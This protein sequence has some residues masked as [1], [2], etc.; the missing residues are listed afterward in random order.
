MR[1]YVMTTGVAFGLLAL[2]HVLRVAQEGWGVA[3]DPV[4]ILTSLG[5][6]GI[7]VWAWRLVRH[8]PRP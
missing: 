8:T 3:A 5:S 7:S 2:A 4:F 1:A 6:A